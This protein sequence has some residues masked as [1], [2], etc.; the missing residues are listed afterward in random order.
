VVFSGK[1][2]RTL[3]LI[4]TITLNGFY[5]Y[6][7]WSIKTVNN[8]YLPLDEKSVNASSDEIKGFHKTA[9]VKLL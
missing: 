9:I 6:Y 5:S 2:E 7:D 4:L 8:K 1:S 3:S